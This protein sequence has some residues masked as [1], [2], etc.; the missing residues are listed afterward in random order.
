MNYSERLLSVVVLIIK[1]FHLK[2]LEKFHSKN[3]CKSDTPF[4]DLESENLGSNII[5]RVVQW[6]KFDF[7]RLFYNGNWLNFNN[8]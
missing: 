6:H 3:E 4:I 8:S 7:Q 5:G 2:Y 1:N